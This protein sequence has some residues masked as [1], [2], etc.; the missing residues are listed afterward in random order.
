MGLPV[1]VLDD[2]T[3]NEIVDEA[4][5][6]IPRYY[7]EWT[8][9]NVHDPGITFIEL[10][11][12]LAEMQIYQLDQITDRNYKNFLQL[13]NFYPCDIQPA[14]VDITFKQIT[15]EIP[16]PA[17]T[18]IF[19]GVEPEQLVY[20]VQEDFNLVPAQIK[21]IITTYDSKTVD[22]TEANETENV[23]F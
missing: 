14:K 8:D 1:P 9:H 18:Q 13:L 11:A 3:F 23:Y 22:N 2:K 20:E 21:S 16:I 7:P 4:R 5:L 10:F 19:T 15:S 17:G 12:W 6:L